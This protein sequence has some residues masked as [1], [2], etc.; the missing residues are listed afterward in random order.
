MNGGIPTCCPLHKV[1]FIHPK[2][3][4]L[5]TPSCTVTQ[6][7]TDVRTVPCH[8][9]VPGPVAENGMLSFEFALRLRVLARPKPFRASGC[10][11]PGAFEGFGKQWDA[12]IICQDEVCHL[13]YCAA[14]EVGRLWCRPRLEFWRKAL[15]TSMKWLTNSGC[16][17]FAINEGVVYKEE[18]LPRARN[19]AFG[20][21]GNTKQFFLAQIM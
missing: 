10:S 21:V 5:S 19:T 15:R 16:Y 2:P 6:L 3:Q 17:S 4:Q 20:S 12:P 7:R 18:D 8:R 9:V 11:F 1:G 14:M 13:C